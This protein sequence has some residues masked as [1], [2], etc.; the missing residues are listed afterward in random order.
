MIRREKNLTNVELE[1]RGINQSDQERRHYEALLDQQKKEL[2]L[3]SSTTK[4]LCPLTAFIGVKRT[5]R[6]RLESNYADEPMSQR[7]R[8]GKVSLSNKIL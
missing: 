3:L 2:I 7:A 6:R 8:L 5:R 4:L 1:L